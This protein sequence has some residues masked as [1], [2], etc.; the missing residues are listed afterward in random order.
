VAQVMD[1]IVLADPSNKEARQLAA[2]A[3]EQMGYMAEAAP[4]R[5][6]YLLAAQKLRGGAAAA[7]RTPGIS[8]N[9]LSAMSAREMFDYL[10]TRIDGPRAG[11]AR[12][13]INWRFSDSKEILAATLSHGALTVTR[14]KVDGEAG[15]VETTRAALE[16]VILGQTTLADAIKGGRVTVIGDARALTDFWALLVDFK[17]GIP[18]VEPR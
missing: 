4:W 16:P 14:G 13:A 5:N 7:A 2:D 15:T 6:S 17:T 11:S 9:V 8:P 1:Q 18:L 10:G 12:I 3:F